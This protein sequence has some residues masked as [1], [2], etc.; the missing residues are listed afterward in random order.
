[1][2]RHKRVE[3]APEGRWSDRRRPCALT[4]TWRRIVVHRRATLPRSVGALVVLCVAGC[5][6]PERLNAGCRWT[7]NAATVES[8]DDRARSAHLIEDVRIAKELGIRYADASAGRMN[9]PAWHRAQESC[10]Q[11]SKSEIQRRHNV[12]NAEI[13][14]ADVARE[15]WPDLLAVFL[16]LAAV[17]LGVSRVIVTRIVAEYDREDR[18]I[19]AALLG[20]LAPVAA[21]VAVALTQIWGVFVEQ[22]RLRSDH[23]S[24]RAFELPASRHGWPLWGTALALFSA[25]AILELA[26]MGKRRATHRAL[27]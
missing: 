16:P 25:V 12:S 3:R 22:L 15:R 17:F 8:L 27:R 2:T 4:D 10:T 13:A 20:A 26:R 11:R 7:E 9:T 23:I 1:M 18:V 6:P 21:A 14:A 5:L 24:Y 19:A